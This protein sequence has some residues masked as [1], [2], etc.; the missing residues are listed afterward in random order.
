MAFPVTKRNG[1]RSRSERKAEGWDGLL[2]VVKTVNQ[3]GNDSL[4]ET[5]EQRATS[6]PWSAGSKLSLTSDKFAHFLGGK[7]CQNRAPPDQNPRS[8]PNVPEPLKRR[9]I[10][11]FRFF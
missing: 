3:C 1:K 10:E 2:F 8:A 9:G 4:A 5:E 6:Y 7:Q 11:M